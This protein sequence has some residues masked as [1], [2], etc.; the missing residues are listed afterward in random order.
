MSS[1]VSVAR[2][3]TSRTETR[4]E[5]GAS[6]LKARDTG[7]I[8]ASKRAHNSLRRGDFHHIVRLLD[9]YLLRQFIPPLVFAFSPGTPR[10][11]S[12]A[13]NGQAETS[14]RAAKGL[15]DP[16]TDAE[17][18]RYLISRHNEGGLSGDRIAQ[19]PDGDRPAPLPQQNLLPTSY[20][21]QDVEVK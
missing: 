9:R 18:E 7:N 21:R 4:A 8:L 10:S 6:G 19:G 11:D 16:V 15:H 5:A 13:K 1:S 12:L 3:R 2:N 14:K 20:I 17:V